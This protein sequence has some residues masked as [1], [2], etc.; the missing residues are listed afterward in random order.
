M[1]AELRNPGVP[2]AEKADLKAL[3][4]EAE[5]EA[6]KIE[7]YTPEAIEVVCKAIEEAKK[8]VEKPFATQKE[9]DGQIRLLK[10][11]VDEL[12]GSELGY[13]TEK[14]EIIKEKPG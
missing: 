7:V 1:T 3:I 4:E 5:K 8:T 13:Y 14:I 11:A 10:K 2:S 12:K 9:V 6:E